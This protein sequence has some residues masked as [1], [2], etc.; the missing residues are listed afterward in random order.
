MTR[1]VRDHDPTT[2]I[3]RGMLCD[4]CNSYLGWV[5]AARRGREP[6][7]KRRYKEWYIRYLPQINTH[8]KSSTG[9]VYTSVEE[10]RDACIFTYGT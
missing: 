5:E 6:L 7:K 8:L 3:I 2:G 10:E 1:L 4:R 9:V